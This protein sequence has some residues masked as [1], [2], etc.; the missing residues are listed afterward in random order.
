MKLVKSVLVEMILPFLT[1]W[2]FMTVLVDIVAIPTVFRNISN[3]E[4]AGKIGMTLFGKFNCIEM[5]FGMCVLLGTVSIKE[6][7]KWLV[8]FPVLLLSFSIVY[9][10]YMTPMIART[11]IEMHAVAVTDPQYAVFKHQ[12]KIYHDIYRYFDTTKLLMLIIFGIMMTR[13]NL[14]RMHKECV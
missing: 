14:K 11:G 9:T 4:E 5:F 8:A 2:F 1:A 10:F 13:F 12:L 7:P 6:M 3:L